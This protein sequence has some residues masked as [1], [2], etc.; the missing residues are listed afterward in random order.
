VKDEPPQICAELTQMVTK[1]SV[2]KGLAL[3]SLEA[4][5]RLVDDV[6]ASAAADYAAIA[7]AR[8]ERLQAVANL[9]GARLSLRLVRSKIKEAAHT[10]SRWTRA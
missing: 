3:A 7:V 9:H 8:L 6:R 5:V 10:G 4:P 1:R 2:L